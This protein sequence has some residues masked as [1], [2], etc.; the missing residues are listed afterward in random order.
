MPRKRRRS[1]KSKIKWTI[2]KRWRAI[3]ALFIAMMSIFLLIALTSYIYTWKDDQ[4]KVIKL[5][6]DLLFAKDV[7]VQNW[8]GR[9]G[10]IIS[11]ITFYKGIGVASFLLP[12][13]GMGSAII[14]YFKRH[15]ME[16]I[17]LATYL[18]ISILIFPLTFEFL[19]HASP[20]AWGGALG[21][22]L[23]QYLS[24]LIGMVGRF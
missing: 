13:F 16:F 10:A 15:W 3:S 8:L 20:F 5:S 11:F 4:D 14:V 1:Q 2:D 23:F 6:W 12:V 22:S 21:F 7:K 9:F 24:V 17:R 18:S 19:L